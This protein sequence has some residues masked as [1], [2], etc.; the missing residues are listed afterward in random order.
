MQDVASPPLPQSR[1][2][3]QLVSQP[4]RDQQPPC[5]DPLPVAEQDPEPGPAVRHQIGCGARDDVTAIALHLVPAAGQEFAG[6]ESVAGEEA[7]H[8]GG[9]SVARR[10]GVHHHDAAAGAGQDQ[11]G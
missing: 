7:V 11:G 2:V 5:R 8:V 1:D 6:W 3:R 9:R 4:G 10:A